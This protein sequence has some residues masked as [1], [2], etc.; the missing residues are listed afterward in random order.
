M[1]S[2]ED[3]HGT[4]LSV[5]VGVAGVLDALSGT[6]HDLSAAT[7]V[8]GKRC[9]LDLDAVTA[10]RGPVAARALVEYWDDT[11]RLATLVGRGTAAGQDVVVVRRQLGVWRQRT[12]RDKADLAE[13]FEALSRLGPSVTD[14]LDELLGPRDEGEAAAELVVLDRSLPEAL[15]GPATLCEQRRVLRV[16]ARYAPWRDRKLRRLAS[17]EALCD[18]VW[19]EPGPALLEAWAQ[20]HKGHGGPS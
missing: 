10:L 15:G 7:V 5:P 4:P 20:P 14:E 11:R 1:S 8:L 3:H 17:L 9:E 16:V 2:T 12:G 18:E 19:P 13:Q 6:G